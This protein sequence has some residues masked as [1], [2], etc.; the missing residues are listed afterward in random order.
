MF[1]LEQL[2]AWYGGSW[3]IAVAE[4]MEKHEPLEELLATVAHLE[5]R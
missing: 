1:T 2:R 5:G 4:H 3:W